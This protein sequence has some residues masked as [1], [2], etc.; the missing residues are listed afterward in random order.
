[1]AQS[2]G[3]LVAG[4]LCPQYQDPDVP[5]ARTPV[6][7]VP[8]PPYP[9][10]QNPCFPSNRPASVPSNRPPVSGPP[11]TQC[12]D[13]HI[14]SARPPVSPVPPPP[15][16][17]FP[18]AVS[19]RVGCVPSY[20]LGL[21]DTLQPWSPRCPRAPQFVLPH[22]RGSS[23]GQSRIT[24]SAYPQAHYAR[25]MPDSFHLWQRLEAEAG[26]SLYR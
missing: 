6:S 23:H 24:R 11:Y 22:S 13:P 5:S 19:L 8:G 20:P 17:L 4:P 10:C 7:P 12:H 26:T 1:M 16:P 2:L 15:A 18:R 21:G 3:A 14:P 25:M 9:Q